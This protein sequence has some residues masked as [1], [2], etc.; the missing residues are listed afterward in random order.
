LIID[1]SVI[2]K[3]LWEEPGT[4]KV[5]DILNAFKDGLIE[6]EAPT[7]LNYEV[8]NAIRFNEELNPKEKEIA[9]Q[10]FYLLDIETIDLSLEEMK[11][12]IKISNERGTTVYDTSYYILAIKDDGIYL[13]AD[14]EFNKK[15]K[16]E[17]V[18][19]LEEFNL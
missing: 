4:E 11:K 8:A 1:A 6:I 3:G 19:L 9:I 16:D 17:K 12:V 2:A 5:V 18:V 15:I 10:S 13:T 14:E 7:I